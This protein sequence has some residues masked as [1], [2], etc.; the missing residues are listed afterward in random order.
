M[1]V[2]GALA[3]TVLHEASRGMRRGS[4]LK[5]VT[6]KALGVVTFLPFLGPPQRVACTNHLLR[7]TK[8]DFNTHHE[9]RE[10]P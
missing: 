8:R 4:F 10:V 1:A 6:R 9:R 2:V 7:L 5:Y 3:T